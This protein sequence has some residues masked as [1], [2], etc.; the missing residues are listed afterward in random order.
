MSII[1]SLRKYRILGMAIFDFAM[2]ILIVFLVHLYM[3]R[4]P[5]EKQNNRSYMQYFISLGLFI[6]GSIWLGVIFHYLFNVKSQLSYY[7]GF[8]DQPN[9]NR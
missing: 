5:I 2:T 4:N 6:I 8:N 1:T 9:K 7:L 3:W